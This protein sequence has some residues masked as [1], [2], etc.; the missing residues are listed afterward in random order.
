LF[1]ESGATN[2]QLIWN[3]INDKRVSVTNTP[4]EIMTLSQSNLLC[5]TGPVLD[6]VIL[7]QEPGAMIRPMHVFSRTSPA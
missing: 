7:A 3:D 5:I 2:A 4:A 1:A 6:N